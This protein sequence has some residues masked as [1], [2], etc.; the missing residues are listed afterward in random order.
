MISNKTLHTAR[1]CRAG[2]A[3]IR[4]TAIIKLRPKTPSSGKENHAFF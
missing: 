2:L 4:P 1:S 3:A